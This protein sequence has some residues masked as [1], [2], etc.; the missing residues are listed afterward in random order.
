MTPDERFARCDALEVTYEGGSAYT[1]RPDDKGGPTRWGITLATLSA[2]RGHVCT[3]DDVANLTGE[4]AGQIRR[5]NYWDVVSGDDLPD[6]VDLI[7]YDCA[8]N[9]GP[10][11]AVR[12]LQSQL[13]TTPDGIMGPGTLGA[14]AAVTDIPGL[15]NRIGARRAALY[16]GLPTFAM[17]GAGWMNRLTSVMATAKSWALRA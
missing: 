11:T 13:G 17:F 2:W 12:A 9:Q 15:I 7:I 3:P 14:L 6:G 5:K 16:K 1:N 8:I 10:G 4:E